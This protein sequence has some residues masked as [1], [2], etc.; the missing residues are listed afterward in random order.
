MLA[1]PWPYREA[2]RVFIATSVFPPNPE[3]CEPFF[4]NGPRELKALK[5][6]PLPTSHKYSSPFPLGLSLPRSDNG[7]KSP[8]RFSK[9]V[10]IALSSFAEFEH[11]SSI[12]SERGLVFFPSRGYS[13]LKTLRVGK[14]TERGCES[15]NNATSLTGREMGRFYM[16]YREN[17][18]E[19]AL[20]TLL[21]SGPRL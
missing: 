20:L 6:H 19:R 9:R 13:R 17:M 21:Q 3:I 15:G 1:I 14:S 7:T 8:L 12:C 18:C 2:L 5:S 16:N 4:R 11:T 10:E